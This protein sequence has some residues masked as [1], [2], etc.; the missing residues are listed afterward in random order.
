LIVVAEGVTATVEAE[1]VGVAPPCADIEGMVTRRDAATT[2]TSATTTLRRDIENIGLGPSIIRS[3]QTG[4]QTLPHTP[5]GQSV[6]NEGPRFGR[7]STMVALTPTELAVSLSALSV[8]A[9]VLTVVVFL[10][11]REEHRRCH[12]YWGVGLFLVFVTVAEEVPLALGVWN[13]PLIVSYLVLVALLVGI[14]SMGSAELALS[15][16]WKSVWFGFL[17]VSSAALVV[18]SVIPS[19]STVSSSIVANGVVTG[20]PPFWVE[21][22]SSLI[23]IPPR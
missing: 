14:L 10:R 20:T 23:T 19:L 12:L 6:L 3:V 11:Y 17:G 8:A 22:L 18:V 13:Q 1:T 9:L 21:V 5:S 2:T 16:L 7:R 15:G 4:K